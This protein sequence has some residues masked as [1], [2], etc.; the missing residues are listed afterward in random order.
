[1]PSFKNLIENRKR[2]FQ[3]TSIEMMTQFEGNLKK[4]G[5]LVHRVNPQVGH[6]V[7][8]N[9]DSSTRADHVVCFAR[10]KLTEMK[11]VRHFKRRAH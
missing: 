1:M 8:G 4:I 2:Y 7:M 3:T 11:K 9:I 10:K 6:S 5:I